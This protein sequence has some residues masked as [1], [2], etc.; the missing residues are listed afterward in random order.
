MESPGWSWEARRSTFSTSPSWW[1][2]SSD[3]EEKC[4]SIGAAKIHQET[5]RAIGAE[6]KREPG[7]LALG[8]KIGCDATSFL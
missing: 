2:D 6:K 1:S 8:V 5:R 7:R 3:G 4:E